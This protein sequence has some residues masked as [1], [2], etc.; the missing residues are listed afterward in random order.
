[1]KGGKIYTMM[2]AKLKELKKKK[3]KKK[4]FLLFFLN[5]QSMAKWLKYRFLKLK[6]CGSIPGLGSY[7]L[8]LFSSFF[9]PPIKKGL[10]SMFA[11]IYI[12]I[13][14]K[15]LHKFYI[16]DVLSTKKKLGH[17]DTLPPVDMRLKCQKW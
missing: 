14:I 12:H 7:S 16:E 1:M 3:K 4:K 10:L 8:L 5:T 2:Y 6:V 13:L 9:S 15:P 17:Q 11:Y